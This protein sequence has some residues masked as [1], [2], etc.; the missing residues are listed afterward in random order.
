MNSEN[1]VIAVV[2]MAG[3]GKSEVAQ[4]FVAHGYIRVRFGDATD[5]EMKKRGMNVC[6]ANERICREQLRQELGMAAYAIVNQPR[7]DAALKTSNVVADGL[8]SWEEYL[9]LKSYYGD[10]FAVVAVNASPKTRYQ[11]LSCRGIRPLTFN[12]ASSRD[13]SEI[14]NLNKGGPIAMAD[15]TLINESDLDDLKQQTEAV[16]ISIAN[17]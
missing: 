3:S 5:G 2:G 14:E 10:R 15:Y 7:I 16:L 9:S 6:E 13:K 1:K 17:I 11:R 12:E 4:V 8:Y